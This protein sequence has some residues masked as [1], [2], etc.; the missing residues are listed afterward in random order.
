MQPLTSSDTEAE[1]AR[2]S[3]NELVSK[4]RLV[5]E[6][7]KRRGEFLS[8]AMLGEPAWDMLLGL[9]IDRDRRLSVGWLVTMV[10]VPQTTALRWIDY[11]EKEHLVAKRQDP[12]DRRVVYIELLD[13]GREALDS[14]FTSSPAELRPNGDNPSR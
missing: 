11:L 4:A 13:R 5:F 7:R 8:R 3:R 6:E 9:Y 2:C 10:G 14:Y 12:D 1:S